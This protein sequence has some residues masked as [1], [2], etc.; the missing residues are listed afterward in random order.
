MP[1]TGDDV[2]VHGQESQP[3]AGLEEAH[4]VLPVSRIVD[5]EKLAE[6]AATKLDPALA[7]EVLPRRRPPLPEGFSATAAA[8]TERRPTRVGI[9]S[10]APS[11]AGAAVSPP[12][13]RSFMGLGS[14]DNPF[15]L[16]PPDT[17]VAVGPNHVFEQVNVVARIHDKDGDVLTTFGLDTFYGVPAGWSGTDPKVIYDAL[18]GRYFSTYFAFQDNVLG[19]DFAVLYIAVSADDNPNGNGGTSQM[20]EEAKKEVEDEERLA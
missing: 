1:A 18:S 19:D 16:A 9:Q 6:T 5:T 8:P 2:T 20:L 14:T 4:L 10:A 13:L 12:N 11:P 15:G 7:V 3:P 17:Q